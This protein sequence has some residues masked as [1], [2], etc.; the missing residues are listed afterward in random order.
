MQTHV[1]IFLTELSYI[2]GRES[3]APNI[4]C[5]V[6]LGARALFFTH[7]YLAQGNLITKID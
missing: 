1:R 6:E 2:L 3:L 4:S 5:A 7:F